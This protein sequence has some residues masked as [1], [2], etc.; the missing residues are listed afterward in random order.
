VPLPV[1]N[2]V[3]VAEGVK[4]HLGRFLT[5][6]DDVPAV[7]DAEAWKELTASAQAYGEREDLAPYGS[8]PVSLPPP[9]S[10]AVDITRVLPDDAA[11]DFG[12]QV[13]ALVRAPEDVRSED[14]VKPYWDPVLVE[15]DAAYAEFID[16]LLFANLT[17]LCFQ[18]ED[19]VG[20]FLCEKVR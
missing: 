18:I 13:R 5:A 20:I 2:A 1:P 14:L 9:G 16:T 6:T 7:S 17:E 15:S 12:S 10:D 4:G 3:S 8:A 11:A 19:E